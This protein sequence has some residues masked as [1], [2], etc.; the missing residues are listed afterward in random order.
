MV[1]QWWCCKL[2]RGSSDGSDAE[3][4]RTGL[5]LGHNVS[6]GKVLS[7]AKAFADIYVSGN[8]GYALVALYPAEGII[9]RRHVSCYTGLS[10]V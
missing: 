5:L 4:R 8:G 9:A 1:A 6:R 2:C 10:R 3:A 7:R